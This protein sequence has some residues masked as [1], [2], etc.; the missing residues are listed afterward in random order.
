M[1]KIQSCHQEKAAY[2]YLRQSTMGQVRHNQESTE[3]QYALKDRALQLGWFPET[4]RTLDGDL[5]I[6]GADSTNRG[7]FKIL[8]ADVSMGKVGAVFAL[9]ASRLSRSCS[10]WHRLLELCA[11]TSTLIID[12]DGCYDPADFNDQLLLGL[13][14]TRS[15]AELHCIRLRLQGGKLNQAKKGLLRFPLPVGFC[16]DDEKNVVLDPDKEVRSAV[17]S[18]FSVF[19]EVGSA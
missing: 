5:G 17:R 6:S 1:S 10:D 4:I 9:E 12:E 8:V 19:R 2:I 15:Q 16:Y 7:D 13:K 14:G 11:L 3:R 18:I